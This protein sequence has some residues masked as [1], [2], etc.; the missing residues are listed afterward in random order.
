MKQ[1]TVVQIFAIQLKHNLRVTMETMPSNHVVK[2]STV[3]NRS[4]V[5]K[6]RQ[7][8]KAERLRASKT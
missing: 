6:Q 1:T 8:R 4:S 7:I 3:G 5:I 2:D